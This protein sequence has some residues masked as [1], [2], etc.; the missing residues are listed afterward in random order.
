MDVDGRCQ[1]I[2]NAFAAATF[3]GHLQVMDLLLTYGADINAQDD[4]GENAAIKIAFHSKDQKERI[5]KFLLDKGAT[6]GTNGRQISKTFR[7]ALQ[8]AEAGDIPV[9]KA[10]LESG[11]INVNFM[12]DDKETALHWCA[13]SD[14]SGIVD[15][16]VEHGADP[17]IPD[18]T[19]GMTPLASAIYSNSNGVVQRLLDNGAQT[20]APDRNGMFL[21][22][23]AG[24]N[25]NMSI[26]NMLLEKGAQVDAKGGP[27]METALLAAV[28]VGNEHIVKGL[29]ANGANVH[30]DDNESW[31]ALNWA[32]KAGMENVVKLLVSKSA[33]LG[34]TDQ[35]G[36]TAMM[37]AAGAGKEDI[38]N[39]LIA[40][41]AKVDAEDDEGRVAL[42]W[43]LD[44]GMGN[45]VKLL[46][47]KSARLDATNQRGKTA[48][49]GQPEQGKWT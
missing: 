39:V 7:K 35:Q 30:A 43:A 8:A 5:L 12:L 36:R 44:A 2:N 46:V 24:I 48:L 42:I 47:A 15:A 38:V 49:M 11:R 40:R 45:T 33:K 28:K 29:I 32:V 4:N 21:L 13:R 34:V 14:N 22:M 26:V 41:G 23:K 17:E 6:V 19:W 25:R 27:N 3:A 18:R 37:W 9:L 1:N 10:F 20:E 16:L 31:V